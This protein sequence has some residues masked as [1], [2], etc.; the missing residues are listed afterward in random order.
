MDADSRQ[1][2]GEKLAWADAAKSCLERAV[3]A[4]ES[5]S[6]MRGT[7]SLAND[8]VIGLCAHAILGVH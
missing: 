7:L 8:V 3:K 1:K 6:E 2:Y 4:A 5:D